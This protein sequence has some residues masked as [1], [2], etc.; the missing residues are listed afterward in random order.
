MDAASRTANSDNVFS[1]SLD[2]LLQA[3]PA[4]LSHIAQQLLRSFARHDI[5]EILGILEV[6]GK[7]AGRVQLAQ[8]RE[9]TIAVDGL[10]KGKDTFRLDAGVDRGGNVKERI[11]LHVD[12]VLCKVGVSDISQAAIRRAK[13]YNMEEI[14]SEDVRAGRP[15][16]GAE[17][18]LKSSTTIPDV[19]G[20]PWLAESRL[21]PKLRF[22]RTALRTKPGLFSRTNC[23][24][25]F[26]ASTLLAAY[27]GYARSGS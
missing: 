25:S 27:T 23:Q 4:I 17:L 18:P 8:D 16:S 19:E 10:C 22:G 26:S 21:A 20:C 14:Q 1:I 11:V 13:K 12:E 7:A 3:R 24:A 15:A 2:A 5:A 6:C 9:K